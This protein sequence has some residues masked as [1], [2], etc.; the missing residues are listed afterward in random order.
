MKK[1]IANFGKFFDAHIDKIMAF[2]IA[3]VVFYAFSYAIF[4]FLVTDLLS[5]F[6]TSLFMAAT[7]I[8]PMSD[9]TLMILFKTG[10]I[11]AFILALIFQFSENL[12]ALAVNPKLTLLAIKSIQSKK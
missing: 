12:I 9:V 4:N 8:E 10:F 11:L 1:I 2:S 6:L 3:W 7:T 5:E